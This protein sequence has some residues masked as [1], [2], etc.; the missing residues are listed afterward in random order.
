MEVRRCI[1]T[2]CS[3]EDWNGPNDAMEMEGPQMRVFPAH[4]F[5]GTLPCQLASMS[6][7]V[8]AV[9]VTRTTPF[10]TRACKTPVEWSNHLITRGTLTELSA[11]I[12]VILP[13]SNQ[14]SMLC[15]PGTHG[16][17]RFFAAIKRFR[18]KSRRRLLLVCMSS[19]PTKDHMEFSPSKCDLVLRQKFLFRS[20]DPPALG[21]LQRVIGRRDS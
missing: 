15:H 6:M 17:A 10:R 16:T 20:A 5:T 8:C 4:K 13:A 14:N 9:V 21:F 11:L 1:A 19:W 7:L 12:L 3:L 18:P 2:G